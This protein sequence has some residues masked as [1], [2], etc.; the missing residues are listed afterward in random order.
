MRRD[1]SLSSIKKILILFI[2]CFI[3]LL[4]AN[5]FCYTTEEIFDMTINSVVTVV[6]EDSKGKEMGFG[7]GFF[8]GE[9]IIITNHHVIEESKKGYVNLVG[10]KQNMIY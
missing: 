4:T 10:K 6:M 1:Y 9:G 7:S 5:G 8:I 2:L 3:F